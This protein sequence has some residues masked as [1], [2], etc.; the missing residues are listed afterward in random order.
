MRIPSTSL[1]HLAANLAIGLLA[2]LLPNPA[3]AEPVSI[4]LAGGQQVS[5]EVDHRTNERLLWLRRQEAGIQITSGF[6]WSEIR[7]GQWA[8]EVLT[9]AELRQ[10][11]LGAGTAGLAAHEVKSYP[12]G[13]L[14]ENRSSRPFDSMYDRPAEQMPRRVESLRISACLG[15]WDDDAFVDGLVIQVF[16]LD[17]RGQIVPV[18]G[19]LTFTLVGQ[20]VP[21]SLGSPAQIAPQFRELERGSRLV[22]KRDFAEGPATY[23]LA[24]DRLQPERDVNVDWS[25][26][27]HARL[28]VFG[29]GAFRASAVDVPIRDFSHLRNQFQFHTPQRYAPH[30]IEG[31]PLR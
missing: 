29:Q 4:T 31:I 26:L 9:T 25:A 27:L 1:A 11:A 23:R 16:P 28:G 22:R 13:S 7:N 2:S 18:N 24:F 6:A 21:L 17:H 10:R 3:L 19:D 5:G 20:V 8:N 30:E 12:S 15:Q 14:D